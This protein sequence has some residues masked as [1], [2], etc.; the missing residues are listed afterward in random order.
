MT[1]CR[2]VWSTGQLNPHRLVLKLIWI[3]L[4]FKVW[5]PTNKM[6][7]PLLRDCSSDNDKV[8]DL[9]DGWA[10]RII[11][12]QSGSSSGIWDANLHPPPE[13][14]H[15]VHKYQ[16]SSSRWELSYFKL[17]LVFVI[18]FG[19]LVFSETPLFSW[20]HGIPHQPPW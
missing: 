12:R 2:G 18:Y 7:Y 8:Y 17:R 14:H 5:T 9:P 6:S 16:L 1:D 13:Y 15:K 10:K 3:F 11:K 4:L 19:F 20:T